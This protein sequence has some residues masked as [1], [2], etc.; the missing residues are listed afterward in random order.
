MIILKY[1][2]YEFGASFVHVVSAYC[3][4]RRHDTGHSWT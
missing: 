4:R 1:L 2:D 3:H